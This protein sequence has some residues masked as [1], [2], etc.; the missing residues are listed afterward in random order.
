MWLIFAELDK[1]CQDYGIP[2]ILFEKT[3]P[4]NL[5][6]CFVDYAPLDFVFMDKDGFEYI[7]KGFKYENISFSI[8]SILSY[9]YI[10]D[11]LIIVKCTGSDRDIHIL[12][13]SSSGKV[14]ESQ[15]NIKIS[16]MYNLDTDAIWHMRALKYSL[17]AF[18]IICSIYMIK[19]TNWMKYIIFIFLIYLFINFIVFHHFVIKELWRL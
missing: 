11:S 18:F 14:Q 4:M 6:P 7:G 12:E 17:I 13:F 2:A 1:K 3:Y 15:D 19:K 10:S 9:G 8:D 16:S 5:K